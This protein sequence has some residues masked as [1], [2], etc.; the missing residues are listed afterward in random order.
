MEEI[1]NDERGPDDD[2]KEWIDEMAALSQAECEGLQNSL[3]PVWMIL[4]KVN[5][6]CQYKTPLT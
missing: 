3:R 2:S 4:V 5:Y 1:G 6:K